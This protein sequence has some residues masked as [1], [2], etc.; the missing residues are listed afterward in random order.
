MITG[1]TGEYEE[2]QDY[3]F[4]AVD[5]TGTVRDR[6]SFYGPYDAG[7]ELARKRGALYDAVAIHVEH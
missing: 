6:F 1:E 5:A 7:M 3:V 2:S 4:E